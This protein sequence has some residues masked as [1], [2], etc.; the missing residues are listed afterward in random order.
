MIIYLG[1]A[2]E[3]QFRTAS[4]SECPES[5][6]ENGDI[7]GKLDRHP[8]AVKSRTRD[9]AEGAGRCDG[10]NA[11]CEARKVVIDTVPPG[12]GRA[13][14]GAAVSTLVCPYE[15]RLLRDCMPLPSRGVALCAAF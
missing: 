15:R 6:G 7:R 5:S 10:D 14:R 8:R 11:F 2:P 13:E 4:R 12:T 9:C 1:A 3:S